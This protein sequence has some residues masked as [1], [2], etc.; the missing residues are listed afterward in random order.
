MSSLDLDFFKTHKDKLPNNIAY[1][2]RDNIIIIDNNRALDDFL[3][4]C[5][6]NYVEGIITETK[7]VSE[8]K[9]PL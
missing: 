1:D 4:V 2:I 5:A 7:Y 3:N 9:E 6:D 8:T